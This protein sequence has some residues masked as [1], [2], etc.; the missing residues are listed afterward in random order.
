[1]AEY[2]IQDSTLSSISSVVKDLIGTTAKIPVSDFSKHVTDIA[3]TLRGKFKGSGVTNITSAMLP[4]IT[5]LGFYC[6]W[7]CG[8]LT[9]VDLPNITAVDDNVF[10]AC[11]ALQNVNLPNLRK[12]GAGLFYQCDSLES[13]D[14]P[15][16]EYIGEN[17]VDIGYQLTLTFGRCPNLKTVNV[18]VLKNLSMYSFYECT[19]LTELCFPMV[20]NVSIEVFKGCT[21]LNKVDFH[22]LKIISQDAFKDCTSLTAVIIRADAVP[23]MAYNYPFTNT[24]INNGTGYIYVPAALVDTYKTDEAWMEYASQIRAIEDYPDIC[25]T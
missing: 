13:V 22:A 25:G 11:T 21:N 5:R 24:P 14:L 17:T 12:T 6:F 9:T 16:L 20:E 10:Y 3:H 8:T 4:G 1:M 7:L 19:S 2:L 15:S 18:P 23:G